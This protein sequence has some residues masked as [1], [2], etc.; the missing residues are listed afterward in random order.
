MELTGIGLFMVDVVGESNYQENLERI[1]GGKKTESADMVVAASLVL[2]DDNRFD[3][4]AVRVDICGLTVGYLDKSTAKGFRAFIENNQYPGNSFGCRAQI[5]GG[6]DRG[7]GDTGLFGVCLDLPKFPK[8]PR[9]PQNSPTYTTP[10]SGFTTRREFRRPKEIG[11]DIDRESSLV[12]SLL[13]LI[14]LFFK[15]AYRF[16]LLVVLLFVS[17]IAWQ[18]WNRPAIEPE[19]QNQP[20][21]QQPAAI[22]NQPQIVNQ[23]PE[24]NQPAPEK[25]KELMPEQK[26]AV[27]E[28][29]PKN[30]VGELKSPTESTVAAEK[31]LKEWSA[32]WPIFIKAKNEKTFDQEKPTPNYAASKSAVGKAFLTIKSLMQAEDLD[33]G[34]REKLSNALKAIEAHKEFAN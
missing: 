20:V 31:L 1:A 16:A 17:L 19:K 2:E 15:I 29:I 24:I 12:G 22:N 6:W 26:S 8:R 13:G 7:N 23:K 9:K 11:F 30:K 21:V 34:V 32:V 3:G 4:N 14:G 27:A 33:S 28:L 5:N 18:I 25:P 10:P